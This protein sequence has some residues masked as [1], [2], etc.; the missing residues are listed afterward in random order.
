MVQRWDVFVSY[1]HEDQAWVQV[2]AEN[3]LRAGCE[4]F[5]DQWEV[6][7]GSRLAQ[8]LQEGLES[9]GVVVLVVSRAAVGKAWWQEEFAAAMAGAVAGVQR[10]VP[11]L[12]D[13]VALP[14]FVANRVWVD[15]R[16]LD[17]PAQYEER[18]TD[19]VR[20]VQGVAPEARPQRD[21][22]IVVPPGV[23]RAEGPKASRLC[24]DRQRVVF[25]CANGEW[26]HS[27]LGVD[28]GLRTLVWEVERA[29]SRPAD[30][31]V[32]KAPDTAVG[33]VLH[34][35]L[36]ELGRALGSRFLVGDAGVALAREATRS[37][38]RLAVQVDDPEWADLPWETLVLPGQ[39]EPL[40]LQ[41]GVQM[42]RTVAVAEPVAVRVPGPLRILAVIA[43]PERGGG[44]LLD[45]ELLDHEAELAR[46]LAVVDPS[47]REQNAHVRVLNW[48]SR[49]AIRQALAEERFHVLHISCHA[50]PGALILESDTG[51][52]DV[53]T[54]RELVDD[55]LVT[56][57]EV[58][59]VVLAGCST[60][61]ADRESPHP[62]LPENQ[63]EQALPGLA[64]D[65]LHAGVPA[66]LAMTA[67]VT[68]SYATELC[69]QMY[70]EL[71]RRPEPVALTELSTVRRRL[72]AQRRQRPAEDPGAVWA[73]WATPALF[74]AGP[75]LP[76]YRRADGMAP[77]PA[78]PET[79]PALGAMIRRV[80]DFVGRRAELRSLVRELR[81]G[82]RGVMLRGVVLHGIGGVGKS[83]LATQLVDQLG[84]QAGLVVPIV[85]SARV[86]LIIDEIRQRLHASCLR[87]A[88]DELHPHRQLVAALIDA[89]PP[90]QHRL[91]LIRDVVL[92][93]LPILLILD[94]A[95]D[96]LTARGT[97]HEFSDQ[98]LAEFLASWV[99]LDRTRL[100]VTSRHPFPLP[101]R[102]HRRLACHHLGP[103]SA[104]ET[105]KLIWRLP[106]L[107]ALTAA[108]RQRAYTDLGGHP[109]SL[110]YLDAL[111][112]GGQ[113]RFDDVADRLEAALDKRGITHPDR[114]LGGVAGNLDRA[115]AETITLTVDDVLLPEL[116]TRL[117]PTP[118]ARSLL[119]GAAGYRRPVDRIGLAWQIAP[120]QQSPADPDRD[121]RM[122]AT[123]ELITEMRRSSK[124]AP[125][126]GLTE[127]MLQQYQRDWD[128]R[129]QPPL[130]IP[131][132]LDE[133][134]S[135]LLTLGLIAPLPSPDTGEETGHYLVHRW[136][137]A[138][139]TK[140]THAEEL[141]D[142][143]RRAAQFWHWR[144]GEWPQ[145]RIIAIPHLV[146]AR[147]H[148]H[149]AH[150]LI[151][152]LALTFR[153]CEQLHTWGAWTW[154]EDLYTE[155]LTWLS[156]RSSAT[157]KEELGH[158][159]GIA[160]CYYQLGVIAQLRGDYAQAE[161][162]Y[163][164]SLAIKEEIGDR[165]GI[166]ACY[167][168][169]GMIA[170][171]RGDYAQAEQRYQASL[172]IDEE[173]GDRVGIAASYG[174]LGMIA[175]ERGD[176][177]QA[178]QRYQ[179]SLAISEEL[180]DRAGI[181]ACYHQL[182]MIAQERGDYAQA[183]Q[184]YQASLAIDEELGDRAGIAASYHQLGM[185]A[186][187]RGDHAQAEQRYQASLA[188][189]E[190]LGDRAGIA[191]S[192]HQLGVIAQQRGDYDRAEQ[193][194]QAS[195]AISEELGNRASIATTTGQLGALRTQQGRPVE[196]IS[197]NIS[198]L[199]IRR[200]LESPEAS[201]DVFW[202]SR[203]RQEIGEENFTETLSNL[204]DVD[205]I[206]LVIDIL[207]KFDNEGDPH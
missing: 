74:L 47:R 70:Q 68:D 91:A 62:G 158:R 123:G 77:V 87:A 58:P 75:P 26:S 196:G 67:P 179:A 102:A 33:G 12:L 49:A 171:L 135:T 35:R 169:L 96:N 141:I 31:V 79:V 185:I 10:L 162:R 147:Y 144:A 152:A 27:P 155:T 153:I 163:Q 15:F 150:D 124:S 40:V 110:E 118:L 61:L 55:V 207:N 66:V 63:G 39:Q 37:S 29:R 19:L 186:Q 126:V 93:E 80:G 8:R 65:L 177:A 97:E 193:R 200:E 138:A 76:L 28:G 187:R 17:A 43:S 21:G 168:Q 170:Q 98:Q 151:D 20:A 161:Q 57:H 32:W 167:H 88:R 105:R 103:L 197:Y 121:Q 5:F 139:L 53:V 166:A 134:L 143:H 142:A 115:L 56:D 125:E 184:R 114:W 108:Q 86:D 73:E 198:A 83:S 165:A 199:A 174:Q 48:G 30:S 201:I 18:F 101:H 112:R 204:L 160:A 133:A 104:A 178:E 205:S 137:A 64:R 132:D 130:A 46:I 181:A 194:Y 175:Q 189:S 173:L 13:D 6:V 99:M 54:A 36:M 7:G 154:E 24:I 4:V 94:N 42:H 23:Y 113:A 117:D 129:R 149:Q 100:L 78:R 156:P 45:R 52:A 14:P 3:L 22:G 159:A 107:D 51:E 25:S 120:I 202:L 148:H 85:G 16:D 50:K 90:W 164:D 9:A 191:I 111:L 190:E 82:R 140:Y 2:L 183:E 203:Q 176:Y 109:R 95:E 192:Y 69:A 59:L 206:R 195:L 119:L 11:V 128:Q 89:S 131:P 157:S 84:A 127:D 116:L 122:R 136:T 172:A 1:A 106:A 71:A 34:S 145:H 44:D 182:G 92:P 38:L 188:I 146:E 81:G 180:G 60:A 41:R 72:E